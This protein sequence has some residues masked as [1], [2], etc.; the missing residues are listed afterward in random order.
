MQTAQ[1]GLP[2]QKR[3]FLG[4]LAVL[5]GYPVQSQSAGRQWAG[6]LSLAR[7]RA[8]TSRRDQLRLFLCSCRRRRREARRQPMPARLYHRDSRSSQCG[9][10]DADAHRLG[11]CCGENY[12]WRREEAEAFVTTVKHV[13]VPC[14]DTDRGAPS[15]CDLSQFSVLRTSGSLLALFGAALGV[16]LCGFTLRFV[17]YPFVQHNSE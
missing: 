8:S 11:A 5:T 16:L 10:W 14:G 13:T 12:T 2:H 3:R 15:C 4:S 17:L 6:P 9:D 1:R 7:S